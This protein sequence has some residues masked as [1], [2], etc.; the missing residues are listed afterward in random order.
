MQSGDVAGLWIC[1]SRFYFFKERVTTGLLFHFEVMIASDVFTSM[2]FF[3][4]KMASFPKIT[5][6]MLCEKSKQ[7]FKG[8]VCNV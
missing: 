2:F 5:A 7:A 1:L 8:P 6:W 3:Y 4:P